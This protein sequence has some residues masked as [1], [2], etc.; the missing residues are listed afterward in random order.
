[1]YPGLLSKQEAAK[2]VNPQISPSDLVKKIKVSQQ[3]IAFEG[4]NL[5]DSYSGHNDLGVLI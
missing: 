4:L 5:P 3:Y 1:M 2:L